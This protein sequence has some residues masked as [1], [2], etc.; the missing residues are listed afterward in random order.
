MSLI[1]SGPDVYTRLK[2]WQGC[3]VLAVAGPG[4]WRTPVPLRVA[5]SYVNIAHK[6]YASRSRDIGSSSWA[7][8]SSWLRFSATS[9]VI[10][11]IVETGSTYLR[12]KNNLQ[13]SGDHGRQRP[14]YYQ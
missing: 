2:A 6:Y 10:V 1:E 4:M 13:S 5:T 14:V 11:D 12:K 8:P 3:R 7:A 9:D